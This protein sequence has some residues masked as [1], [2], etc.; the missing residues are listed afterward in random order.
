MPNHF[1]P[2]SVNLLIHIAYI[3]LS[4]TISVFEYATA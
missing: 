3:N 1:S 4:V 2:V